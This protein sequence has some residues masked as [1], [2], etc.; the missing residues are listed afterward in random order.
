[1]VDPPFIT[2]AD[3]FSDA[4]PP[5]TGW[6]D[7][8]VG[9]SVCALD[10]DGAMWC[11]QGVGDLRLVDVGPFVSVSQNGWG[12]TCGVTDGGSLRCDIGGSDGFVLTEIY[13]AVSG[14]SEA[15]CGLQAFGRARCWPEANDVPGPFQSVGAGDRFACGILKSS[16]SL[17]CWSIAFV[18]AGRDRVFQ[19]VRWL[20][21]E[22]WN[23]D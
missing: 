14:S 23:R 7:L 20:R 16:G 13:T 21:P 22:L 3:A 18:S 10:A 19:G 4:S 11:G 5:T 8:S 12:E 6:I 15:G 17:Q 2:D 1:L 9:F